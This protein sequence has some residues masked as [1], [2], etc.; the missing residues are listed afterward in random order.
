MLNL[1]WALAHR[2][3]CGLANCRRHVLAAA[4]TV[5]AGSFRKGKPLSGDG[6]P[7]KPQSLARSWASIAP[8]RSLEQ[9]ALTVMLGIGPKSEQTQECFPH[10]TYRSVTLLQSRSKP[11]YLVTRFV[12][13]KI[14]LV[15]TRITS[16]VSP[17]E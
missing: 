1:S 13:M 3:S 8:H 9:P 2:I 12:T 6:A 16:M 15:V 4:I 7:A 11:K 17:S 10:S 14:A 5:N